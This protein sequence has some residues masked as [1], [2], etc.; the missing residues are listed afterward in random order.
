M[1][2]CPLLNDHSQLAQGPVPIQFFYNLMIDR[3]SMVTRIVSDQDVAVKFY[4]EKLGFE[5]RMDHPGPHGRFLAV[6]P[7]TDDQVDL[8]LMEPDG[9]DQEEASRLSELIGNDAGLIYAVDNC[10]AICE[11]LVEKGVKFRSE[12]EAM[13]WGVQAVILDP[14]G[15]EIVLQEPTSES[16]WDY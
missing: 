10:R 15:N 4:T 1:L 9:F 14:D 5:K 3:L 6:A 13:P 11:T 2:V 12:P 7:P 8:I 16:E